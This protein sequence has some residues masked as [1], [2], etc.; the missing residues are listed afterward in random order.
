MTSAF[1]PP[2]PD[3]AAPDSAKRVKYT[4]GM[5]LGADDFEQEHA[6]LEGR[7][8]WLARDLLGY[9]TANGLQVTV[10]QDAG[11]EPLVQVSC[12]TAITPRGDL[13]RVTPA[14][15]APLDSWL[16]TN[17]ADVSARLPSSPP[18]SLPLYVVLCYDTCETDARPIPGEPCRS[19]AD[20]M[21]PARIADAFRLELRLDAPVHDEERAVRQFVQ[22]A[23][24]TVDIGDGPTTGSVDDFLALLR[25]AA[26]VSSPTSPPSSPPSPDFD[27]VSPYERFTIDRNDACEYLRAALRV[28]TTELRPL[29][30]EEFGACQCC[31]GQTTPTPAAPETCLL[32]ARLQVTLAPDG[33][34]DAAVPVDVIEDDRPILAPLRLL[35]EWMTCGPGEAGSGG[36]VGP[37]GPRGDQGLVGEQGVRGDRGPTGDAGPVGPTGATGPQGAVGPDGPDGVVGPDGP[38][39]AAGPIGATGPTGATGALGAPGVAGPQGAA[40]AD[41]A[42]GPTGAQGPAGPQGDAGPPGPAGVPGP[43]GD[44]GVAGPTGAAGPQGGAGVAGPTGAAGPAGGPGPVGV[45]GPAGIPGSAGAPGVQGAQGLQGLQGAQGPAGDPAVLI[46]QFVETAPKAGRY[47]IV[48]GGEIGIGAAPGYNGLRVVA[49]SANG[50]F[51]IRYDTIDDDVKAK[52]QLVVKVTPVFDPRLKTMWLA[53]YMDLT[54]AGILVRVIP[55]PDNTG[56]T[57]NIW[58]AVRLMVEVSM[59]NPRG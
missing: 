7:D 42:A 16:L 24:D 59:F 50:V 51:T 53:N 15:C 27:P 33:R 38:V 1:A 23:T 47:A 44:A 39:G 34:V 26:R 10:R 55:V 49:V 18:S 54:T 9:G 31:S 2:A 46:G 14:Q 25:D 30:H 48:A 35:Q 56:V 4:L 37:R 12:G 22:W 20:T 28:W 11:T 21:A 40:G 6:W 57:Q 13:V 5:I 36:A 45:Q 58:N 19:E 3:L 43:Q 8:R 52:A 32:L 17:S 41:G 29:W